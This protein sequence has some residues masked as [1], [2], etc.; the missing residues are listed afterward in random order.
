MV[1]YRPVR[2]HSNVGCVAC[3]G[4]TSPLRF[5]DAAFAD[6]LAVDIERPGPTLVE[7]P[8]VVGKIVDQCDVAFGQGFA[9]S[10]V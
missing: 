10:F 7:A 1:R 8:T 6:F 2:I 9:A 5:V 4:I 3:E